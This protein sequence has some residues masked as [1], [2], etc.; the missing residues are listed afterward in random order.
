MC[1]SNVLYLLVVHLYFNSSCVL[2]TVK[3]KEQNKYINFHV[4]FVNKFT[5]SWCFME[6][7]SWAIKLSFMAFNSMHFGKKF[8]RIFMGYDMISSWVFM[9]H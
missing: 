5:N 4:V 3:A 9:D 7:N 1:N 8:H 6:N 2:C